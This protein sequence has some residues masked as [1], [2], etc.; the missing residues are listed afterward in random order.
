[1]LTSMQ[2]EEG[3][4]WPVQ[5][6]SQHTLHMQIVFDLTAIEISLAAVAMG[7]LR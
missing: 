1:M 2:T 7:I 3:S 4:T 6:N 5:I